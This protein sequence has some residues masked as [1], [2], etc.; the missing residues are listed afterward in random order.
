MVFEIGQ[1]TVVENARDIGAED[2]GKAAGAPKNRGAENLDPALRNAQRAPANPRNVRLQLP[3]G[4]AASGRQQARQQQ[5]LNNH[6][7]QTV[8]QMA[9]RLV[10]GDEDHQPLG[11]NDF[12]R[13]MILAFCKNRLNQE[14]V[15]QQFAS[16]QNFAEV[17]NGIRQMLETERTS[18]AYGEFK[19]AIEDA[20]E[21]GFKVPLRRLLND[22]QWSGAGYDAALK[23][24]IL[25]EMAKR[26][27]AMLTRDPKGRVTADSAKAV[28][29][30]VHCVVKNFAECRVA[31]LKEVKN[32]SNFCIDDG[33]GRPEKPK[34]T[35]AR[36]SALLKGVFDGFD[37]V[38]SFKRQTKA[39]LE[40][41][42]AF[43][44][45]KI[46][47]LCRF[48]E[49]GE[50]KRAALAE[51]VKQ[52]LD[53]APVPEVILAQ[54]DLLP[55]EGVTVDQA[56]E[57]IDNVGREVN[58]R[59]LT[60]KV[61]KIKDPDV[62]A[63]YL[64]QIQE[65]IG[66]AQSIRFRLHYVKTVEEAAQGFRQVV[67][68]L[69]EGTD[70]AGAPAGFWRQVKRLM[71]EQIKTLVYYDSSKE[72][73]ERDE[74]LAD[75]L[76][77][78][79]EFHA[80]VKNFDAGLEFIG[81]R[82]PEWKPA[83]KA[84][85]AET[86]KFVKEM[87]PDEH[88]NVFSERALEIE[89]LV[90]GD[91]PQCQL[92]IRN[93]GLYAKVLSLVGITPEQQRRVA[94]KEAALYELFDSC[95]PSL[96][97]VI[98]LLYGEDQDP[99]P[100]KAD[101]RDLANCCQSFNDSLLL[102]RLSKRWSPVASAQRMFREQFDEN[103][104]DF[105]F[106]SRSKRQNMVDRAVIKSFGSHHFKSFKD[107]LARGLKESAAI[108]NFLGSKDFDLA[109]F[110]TPPALRLDGTMSVASAEAKLRGMLRPRTQPLDKVGKASIEIKQPDGRTTKV[111]DGSDGAASPDDLA[112][113]TRGAP[114]TKS[115][116]VLKALK[117][118]CGDNDLQYLLALQTMTPEGIQSF[119]SLVQEGGDL[120][121]AF[122]VT[123]KA[124]GDLVVTARNGD[125]KALTQLEA[126]VVIT[127]DGKVSVTALHVALSDWELFNQTQAPDIGA[128]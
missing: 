88:L 74:L 86:M 98:D 111:H 33:S 73:P 5:A 34:L 127:Q 87:V 66:N 76:K 95:D 8:E 114:S 121:L 120:P 85:Y 68:E 97:V 104:P 90:S 20:M 82:H 32:F 16:L 25:H 84:L 11:D 93:R 51:I 49:Q 78:V 46:D 123:K 91:H 58:L 2:I 35:L 103:D 6:W 48:C 30:A 4:H 113:F 106:L 31:A 14:A 96:Q 67:E 12:D 22:P 10:A 28:K 65:D 26:L 53:T 29:E 64:Q 126:S 59:E 24:D 37:N 112:R 89:A 77:S 47:W 52:W 13:Q 15:K 70:Y 56:A 60:E 122:H 55:E 39:L 105:M 50:G 27:P 57:I 119:G 102:A 69:E 83:Q 92:P 110:N 9:S 38:K 107:G 40:R 54:L 63:A 23:R 36:K 42:E 116:Q 80:A 19:A 7:Q 45:V 44:P 71:S 101:L 3:A 94:E 109:S 21:A 124:N 72:L 61:S 75:F 118:L 79:D 100:E 18:E 43:T 115:E 99:V 117:E 17:E 81:R 1:W 41:V 108:N 125:P 128:N 62:Q